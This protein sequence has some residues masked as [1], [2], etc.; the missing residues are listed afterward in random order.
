[1][2]AFILFLVG[3][4][5][6]SGLN[7]FAQPFTL[8][9]NQTNIALAPGFNHAAIQVGITPGGTGFNYALLQAAS[10]SAWVSP[11][12]DSASGSLRL[13][14]STA[15]LTAASYSATITLTH[16]TDSQTLLVSA[17]GAALSVFKLI[18]DPFRSRVYGLSQQ[19]LNLG[20]V[21]VLDPIAER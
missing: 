5:L 2:R 9:S 21:V 12:V 15:A 16:G 7:V 14:F 4:S 18:D 1:M 13:S 8:A 19:G 11:S 17:T 6:L 3:S 20:S 10:N